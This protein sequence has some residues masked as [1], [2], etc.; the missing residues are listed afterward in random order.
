M[1]TFMSC[2]HAIP[3]KSGW[4]YCELRGGTVTPGVCTHCDINSTDEQIQQRRVA[5]AEQELA[6]ERHQ[7]AWKAASEWAA[8]NAPDMLARANEAN[9]GCNRMARQQAVIVA[10][11]S[12]IV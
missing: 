6:T 9:C 12:A 3:H 2:P 5:R 10:W 1:G 7:T 11:Q 8:L 4:G